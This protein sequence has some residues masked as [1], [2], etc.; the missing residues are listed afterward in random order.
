ML[1]IQATVFL[2]PNFLKEQSPTH[3][4]LLHL[5]QCNSISST[6]HKIFSLGSSKTDIMARRMICFP[7]LFKF[8]KTK[9]TDY[10][11]SHFSHLR[12]YNQPFSSQNN[13]VLITFLNVVKQRMETIGNGCSREQK[14]PNS[15]LDSILDSKMIQGLFCS[16]QYLMVVQ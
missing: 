13:L 14:N 12:F 6:F 5:L 4:M 10:E 9:W 11:S 15:Y 16:K 1:T 8:S 7:L 2:I 3:D